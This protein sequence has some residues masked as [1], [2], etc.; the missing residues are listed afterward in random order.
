MADWDGGQSLEWRIMRVNP[1]T[2]EDDVQVTGV[3]SISISRDATDDCPLLE[4]GSVSFTTRPSVPFEQGWYR[5]EAMDMLGGYERLA[6]ATMLFESDSSSSDRGWWISEVDGKS[7]LYPAKDKKFLAGD[8]VPKG[9]D[10]AEYAAKLLREVTPA[11]VVVE[12][13]FT[14]DDYVVMDAGDTYLSTV[15]KVLMAASW[16]IQIDGRGVIHIVEKPSTPS[17]ELYSGDMGLLEP[18]VSRSFDLSDVPNSYY[19]TSYGEEAHAVNEDPDSPVSYPARGRW[20]DVVDSSP[21]RINGET[22][23]AYARRMLEE[24][25]TVVESYSYNRAFRPEVY[26]FDIVRAYSDKVGMAGDYR[27]LSQS[28]SCGK[29]ITVQEKVGKEVKLWQAT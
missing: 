17:L 2:W 26:P 18:D 20:V 28:L 5:I 15:W 8:Y 4:S 14:V 21:S 6:I 13:G 24:A 9:V 29:G 27:I 11:P 25:S 10:G 12:G 7:V 1:S 19:A 16:C 23:A 3:K 22:M